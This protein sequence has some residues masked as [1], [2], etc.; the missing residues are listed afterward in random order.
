VSEHGYFACADDEQQAAPGSHD[1]V[2]TD[3]DG[4]GRDSRGD[5]TERTRILISSEVREPDPVGARVEG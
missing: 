1:G 2:K 5:P 4:R 3:G